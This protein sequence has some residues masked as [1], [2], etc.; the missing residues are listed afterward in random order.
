M[1]ATCR[2]SMGKRK[3]RREQEHWLLSSM[4]AGF[5]RWNVVCL[6]VFVCA[7]RG[8]AW[9]CVFLHVEVT[10]TELRA[11]AVTAS[12]RLHCCASCLRMEKV[13]LGDQQWLGVMCA[14][15]FCLFFLTT[16]TYP[17]VKWDVFLLLANMSL[18]F[19]FLESKPAAEMSCDSPQARSKVNRDN[20]TLYS[21][22]I[23]AAW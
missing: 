18:H 9:I 7:C 6:R 11:G 20:F 8:A 10:V 3:W 22:V 15:P 19:T 14:R 2:A 5:A 13:H 12:H 21:H 16:F 4:Y 1:S 17:H 23:S